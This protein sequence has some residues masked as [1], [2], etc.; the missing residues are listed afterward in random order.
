LGVGVAHYLGFFIHWEILIWLWLWLT[1]IHLGA[2]FLREYFLQSRRTWLKNQKMDHGSELS[3]INI[4]L[5]LKIFFL[6]GI[7]CLAVSLIPLINLI[8][9][10]NIDLLVLTVFGVVFLL[11]YIIELKTEWLDALGLTI[12]IHAFLYANLI[13]SISYLLQTYR[14]HRFLFLITFPLFFI[15]LALFIVI[16]LEELKEDNSKLSATLAGKLGV[17]NYLRLHNIVIM[18]VFIIASCTHCLVA[19]LAG[20]PDCAW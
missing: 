11:I 5:Q 8:H 6:I 19:N 18:F 9:F 14:M 17:I 15:F 20:E 13:P 7:V 4:D 1:A 3:G 16:S 10:Y 2:M 12:F